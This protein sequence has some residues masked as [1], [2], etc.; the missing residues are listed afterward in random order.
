MKKRKNTYK[1]KVVIYIQLV[2][3]NLL[4]C[5]KNKIYFSFFKTQKNNKGKYFQRKIRKFFLFEKDIG[6]IIFII[7]FNRY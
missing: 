3:K 1:N 7:F 5:G 4:F 6:V 2:K